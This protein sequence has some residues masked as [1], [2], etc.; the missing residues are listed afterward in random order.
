MN[1]K[2]RFFGDRTMLVM[3]ALLS[4]FPPL[5]T[6]LYLPALPHMVESMHTSQGYV[7]L[8][9]SLF[10]LFFSV[11]ILVWGPASEKYGRKPVVLT[12]LGIYVLG[13]MGCALSADVIQL[14]LCRVLQ[15]FGGGAATAVATAMVKDMYSGRKRES[16]LAV[17]MAMVI[18][19]PVIAPVLGAMI[20]KIASWRAVFWLLGG[21]GAVV[22]ALSLF[23]DETL[24]N[25]YSGSMIHA[26][27]RL[28][29]VMRN[30]GFTFLLAT[31]SL[32]P[33]PLMA[34]IAASSFV[35]IRGFGMTEEMYSYYFA[36]NALGAMAGPLLYIRISRW[37]R[38]GNIIAA[39]FGL[40]VVCG[41]LL[42]VAGSLS[43]VLFA[44]AMMVASM[45][46]SLLRPPTANLLLSQQQGDTGSAASLI[47]FTG[48][49]MGSLGMFLISLPTGDLIPYLG[50]MQVA[51]GGVS[52]SLWLLARGRSFIRHEV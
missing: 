15:A 30:P 50:L 1:K 38:A 8:T 10:F 18:I 16:V 7:N 24:E 43:P 34:F 23:L 29:V 26:L 11:G 51:V 27:G 12:G 21:I 17:V 44:L 9:L 20:L 45:G 42:D 48:M 41:I 39:G 35:Y 6:D 19:A 46:M 32:V 33:L 40:M 36:F 49:L 4:A 37:M 25:R 5:S 22:F 2:Q 28:V 14:I 52:G 47:N 31:F 13:S 3:L